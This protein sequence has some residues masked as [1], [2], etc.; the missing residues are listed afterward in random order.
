MKNQ[1][2]QGLPNVMQLEEGFT[3]L[4]SRALTHHLISSSSFF[5]FLFLFLFVCFGLFRA[6]SWPME[7]PRLGVES[8]L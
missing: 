2:G 3:I 5:L 6:S 8:E 1:K 4:K 7:V